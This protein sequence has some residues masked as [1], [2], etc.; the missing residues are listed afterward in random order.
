MLL[1]VST[2]LAILLLFPGVVHTR[3][4]GEKALLAFT[5]LLCI[6]LLDPVQRFIRNKKEEHMDNTWKTWWSN[7]EKADQRRMEAV[8]NRRRE[9]AERRSHRNHH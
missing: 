3:A 7:R 9:L 4:L 1:L 2:G 8:E 6:Y 5:A